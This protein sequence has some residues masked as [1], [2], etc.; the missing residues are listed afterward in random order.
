MTPEQFREL[1]EAGYNRIPVYRE[2]LADLDTPLSTYLKLASGPYSYLFESVQGGEKWG[3]YSIIGLP[4][5][6]VL[7]VFDHRI[8]VSRNGEVVEQAEV[9][10]PLAFVD[11]YQQ[12][13]NAPDLPEL[14]RFNGGLVGYFG[15]DTVRY[16]EK[17]LRHS[18]LSD[19]ICAP[20]ILPT[21][22]YVM[23]GFDNLRGKLHLIVHAD[24]SAKGA[25]EQAHARS[26]DVENQTHCWTA[27]A[28]R[29][30]EHL[31]AKLIS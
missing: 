11:E 28:P 10:D 22:S 5:Q 6:E 21:S 26:D 14:P 4:S 1:A 2:V 9:D 13:F 17:R 16:I 20:S 8:E 27:N 19:K 23:V 7:K 24:P 18:C 25:Y 29:T 15:Y 30:P 12:R 31:R 3:R